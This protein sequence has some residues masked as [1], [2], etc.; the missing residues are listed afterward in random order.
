MALTIGGKRVA[1][2]G[3]RAPAT[4]LSP[5]ERLLVDGLILVNKEIVDAI[6]AEEFADAIRD[7]DPDMFDRL[8]NDVLRWQDVQEVL[9]NA[10]RD[11]V[12]DG[13]LAQARE[14]IR[15]NPR[16]QRSPFADLQYSGR[17]LPSG[18]IVPSDLAGPRPDV[19]MTIATPVEQMFNY[20]SEASVNYSRVRSGQLIRAIDEST[21]VA[22]R[23]LITQAFIEP[24]SVDDTAKLI[25]RIVG[26]HPRWARAVERFHD[27]NVRRLVDTGL[28]SS[29]A[30]RRAD[31]MTAKYREK[32]IRRRAE[33]IARTET[34]QA[35]N[36]GRQMS[37]VASDRAGLVDPRT[38]KEWRTAPLGSRYGPPCPTCTMLRGTRVPWNGTFDNGQQM[39]PAHPNCRCTAVLIPPPRKLT[40]LP[41]QVATESWIEELEALEAEQ[42]RELEAQRVSKHKGGGH[43]QKSHG[44]WAKGSKAREVSVSDIGEAWDAVLTDEARSIDDPQMAHP[45][46]YNP[47]GQMNY[48]LKDG[49]IETVRVRG[50]GPPRIRDYETHTSAGLTRQEAF[51]VEGFGGARTGTPMRPLVPAGPERPPKHL[52]RV[53]S[54]GEFDQARSRGYIKSDERMNLA[55]GE[56]TVTSL[57]TT[58]SFYAPVD[59]SD[60]RVV[61]IKY[62]D[63]DGWRTDTDSYIKTD[64]RVPFERVDLYSSAL[65]QSNNS[66]EKHERGKHDQSSHGA[67]AKGKKL[68][69]QD[70]PMNPETA[71]VHEATWYH[72]TS[73]P[74]LDVLD[75]TG[76]TRYPAQDRYYA[77]RG[78]NFATTDKELA[79]QYARESADMDIAAGVEGVRPTVYRVVPTSD[80]F[81]PD[82]HSGPGGWNDGPEDMN[83]AFELYDNG[84]GVSV[85]FHDVMDIAGAFDAETGEELSVTKMLEMLKHQR[86]KHDQAAHGAWAK[87]RVDD[88]RDAASNGS[89]TG[90][91]RDDLAAIRR[92]PAAYG[93][94]AKDWNRKERAAYGFSTSGGSGD[95]RIVEGLIKSVELGFDI[96]YGRAERQAELLEKLSPEAQ[97]NLVSYFETIRSEGRVFVAANERAAIQIVEKGEFDTVFETNRSNGAVAHDAR[98][99]EEFASH[100]LHP[101]L[102]PN[103]RP[104]YG[105]VAIN[106]PVTIGASNYGNVRFELKPEV[107]TRSTMT[108]GDSLGSHATPVPMSGPPISRADAVAGSMGWYGYSN[109]GRATPVGADEIRDVIDT[110]YGGYVEAQV[111]GGVKIDDVARIHVDGPH[112]DSPEAFD[113]D[114][115]DYPFTVEALAEAAEARGIEIVYHG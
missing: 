51:Q 108:D 107:K 69:N 100:D 85:R 111:K 95:E 80:Y 29:Q 73:R 106:N 15:K 65:S 36:F 82:P 57:R 88:I 90:I 94:E 38:M 2:P 105:Y 52:Y 72:G 58:G 34:Q 75:A 35:L 96:R 39:P 25:R 77:I 93:F 76:R 99:R 110:S 84:V 44:A 12:L 81:D 17:Q 7:L 60:Y 103:L 98:R 13:S 22:V 86:G 70:A 91:T 6:N 18:I 30:E 28:S 19:E 9:D 1:I 89:P 67:W 5:L 49:E 113:R 4:P 66:V 31:E 50:E 14:I 41:S 112:W 55:P 40:G 16:I 43:D 46:R 97:E 64:K 47:R 114:D 3:G 115:E 54:T 104:V 27:N 61:R 21:R 23:E 20:V 68:R 83:A 42:I 56:G 102:D 32:L 26:L 33:M 101:G 87:G 92:N 53:M 24:R 74:D 48:G 78:D 37:W 62:D 11:V 10:L 71:W 63:S 109:E 45:E 8:L 79:A 59:G